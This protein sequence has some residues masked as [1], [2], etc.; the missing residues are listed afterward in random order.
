[1]VQ[2]PPEGSQRII[3]YLNYADPRAAIEFICD[4]FGFEQG[5]L[6]EGPDG[7]VMHCELLYGGEMVMLAGEFVEIGLSSPQSLG[8][9]HAS[10]A[11]YVD[12]LE[13]H[14]ERAKAAGARIVEEPM[15]QFYGDRTYRA[16]DAEGVGWDFHQHMR[17]VSPEE[18]AAA[19]SEQPQ[20]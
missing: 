8:G 1:M 3:P 9:V 14:Y 4:A 15:D 6:L 12:D 10:I 13:A 5:L 2:N 20:G 17:D 7:S 16:L 11:I 18:M 19:M